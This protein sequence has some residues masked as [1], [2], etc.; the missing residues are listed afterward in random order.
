MDESE[1]EDT[2]ERLECEVADLEVVIMGL[3]NELN[4]ANIEIDH[5]ECELTDLTSN[6]LPDALLDFYK[7]INRGD[8]GKVEAMYVETALRANGMDTI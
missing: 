8:D 2:I 7:A 3:E 6:D 1:M 5:L 4:Q